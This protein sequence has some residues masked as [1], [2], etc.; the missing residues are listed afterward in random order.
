M[1]NLPWELPD[2]VASGRHRPN[3]D[4]VI[5]SKTLER[6]LREKPVS[7]FSRATLYRRDRYTQFCAATTTA[8]W[9]GLS[10]PSMA[11]R[12]S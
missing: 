7:V 9:P 10:R 6:A 3:A 5:D 2:H 4:N 11:R 8:S 12:F 1:Q